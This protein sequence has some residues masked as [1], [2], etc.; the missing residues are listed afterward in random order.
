MTDRYAVVGNPVAHSRSPEIHAAFA[1]ECGA[2]IQYDRL[3]A[4]LTAFVQTIDTFRLGGASGANVTLPFKREAFSYANECT[5]RAKRGGSVNTLSFRDNKII[6]DS[7]DGIGL[8]RDIIQNIGYPLCGAKILLIG[9]GGAA[10]GAVGALLDAKPLKLTITNRTLV[11]AEAIAHELGVGDVVTIAAPH[12][13]SRST[14]DVVIDATSSG[15]TGSQSLVA[16]TCFG[17]NTLAYD[18]MYSK[19]LTP[20]LQLAAGAGATTADGLGMLVEQAAE[21]FYVW[22]GVQPQTG[23]IIKRLRQALS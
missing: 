10:R 23:E 8:C 20:F 21:A 1:R 22:R 16:A 9:A 11:N 18:M 5:A 2:D 13:L 14:F 12:E 4:P 7:T 17:K 6:G 19:G 3:L 15:L